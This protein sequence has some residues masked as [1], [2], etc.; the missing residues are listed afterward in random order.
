MTL[1]ELIERLTDLRDVEGIP[2]H[3]EVRIA[4]Q[5]GYPL[6]GDLEAITTVVESEADGDGTEATVY[7]A[8]GNAKDYGSR[9]MWDDDIQ[10][11]DDSEDED[12][13]GDY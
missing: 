9:S 2:G 4:Q 12:E 8:S 13:D 1:D 6:L 10:Y 3:M 5:P 11:P 7:L